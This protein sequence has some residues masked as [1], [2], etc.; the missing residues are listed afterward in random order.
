MDG[1]IGDRWGVT[2]GETLTG[3]IMGAFMSY[4][5]VPEERATTRLRRTRKF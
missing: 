1:V 5:L 2:D 3:T 4:V